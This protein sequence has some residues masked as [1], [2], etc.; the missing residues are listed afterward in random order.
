M[1]TLQWGSPDIS[2]DNIDVEFLFISFCF[3]NKMEVG[4]HQ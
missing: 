4:S 1:S 3:C 2:M